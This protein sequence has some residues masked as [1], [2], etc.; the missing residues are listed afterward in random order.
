[1]G[2]RQA[3]WAIAAAVLIGG[4]IPRTPPTAAPGVPADDLELA[5]AASAPAPTPAR[6]LTPE[7]RRVQELEAQL[8]ER[9]RQIASVQ[10]ELASARA[11]ANGS[12]PAPAAPPAT[13][14]APA[15]GAATGVTAPEAATGSLAAK[16]AELADARRQIASLEGRLQSEVQR[17][18]QVEHEMSR[19]LE[20]TSSGPYER[21]GNVVEAHLREQL[22]S[23]QKEIGD[24]R[25]TLAT[26]RRERGDLERRFATLQ[27][28]LERSGR[29]EGDSEEVAALK[30]RQRRV[31]ASIQQDL[32]ASQEREVQLRNAL[33]QS[34]GSDGV[35]LADSVTNLRAENAALQR[36]L[37]DEHRQNGALSAK[38]KLA[39]RVT[40]LI[41]KMQSSGARPAAAVPMSR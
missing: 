24:L 19:L 23:A 15:T 9:D 26:E 10:Q 12:A 30:E 31:L 36:R 25:A 13:G 28:Q 18:Q 8:A 11:Q 14:D 3:T 22:A 33:E 35:S 7:E 34:E 2:R 20:E 39:G 27:A 21:S 6:V 32:A 4:C 17:R 5:D 41:F 16:D 40:D 1:M 37:D 29:T 38:L